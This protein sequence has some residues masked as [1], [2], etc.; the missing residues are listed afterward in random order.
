M[1]PA[2][3]G[4]VATVTL[5]LPAA[6]ILNGVATHVGTTIA[7]APRDALPVAFRMELDAEPA[8][9]PIATV[10]LPEAVTAV[11]EFTTPPN[12]T[13]LSGMVSLMVG[14]QVAPPSTA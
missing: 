5:I 13:A 14:V 3:N 8:A 2:V 10:A 11:V 12:T 9:V 7:S 4:P 1:T 6:V